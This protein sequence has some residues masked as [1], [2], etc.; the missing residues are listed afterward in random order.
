MKTLLI[1][2]CMLTMVSCTA[3]DVIDAVPLIVDGTTL[4]YE[5]IE[6]AIDDECMTDACITER[7]GDTNPADPSPGYEDQHELFDEDSMIYTEEDLN[8]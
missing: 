5:L 3:G 1:G 6:D 4:V 8:A 2:T 7:T